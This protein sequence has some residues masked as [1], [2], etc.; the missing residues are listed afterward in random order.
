MM[1]GNWDVFQIFS[2]VGINGEKGQTEMKKKMESSQWE[3]NESNKSIL[4]SAGKLCLG[5]RC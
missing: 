3:N 4:F 5:I 1:N 2:V